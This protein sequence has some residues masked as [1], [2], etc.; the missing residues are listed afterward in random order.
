M[1]N[2]K[3]INISQ[4]AVIIY[5]RWTPGNTYSLVVSYHY[6]YHWGMLRNQVQNTECH[7]KLL[8]QNLRFWHWFYAFFLFRIAS[9]C[10]VFIQFNPFVSTFSE[11]LTKFV[12]ILLE[13]E[14]QK[15]IGWVSRKDKVVNIFLWWTRVKEAAYF[16]CY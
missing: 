15:A 10:S 7:S 12:Y 8:P 14:Q 4:L 6:I 9:F 13:W 16:I 3:R 11:R 2:W 5:Q 1:N